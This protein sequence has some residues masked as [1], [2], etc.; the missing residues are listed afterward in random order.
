MIQPIIIQ[1]APTK[2]IMLWRLNG[3]V[4]G[5]TLHLSIFIRVQTSVQFTVCKRR[6]PPMYWLTAD[7]TLNIISKCILHEMFFTVIM[8]LE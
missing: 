6:Y 1:Y 3:W 7:K 8:Y 5:E 4:N 2:D